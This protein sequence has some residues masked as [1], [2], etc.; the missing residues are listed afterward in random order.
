MYW[1]R[2]WLGLSLS[3]SGRIL[4]FSKSRFTP[5]ESDETHSHSDMVRGLVPSM[6][7][8]K[9]WSILSWWEDWFLPWQIWVLSHFDMTV[10]C[11]PT[12]SDIRAIAIIGMELPGEVP[13]KLSFR[14]KGHF[15]MTMR[16]VLT[17]SDMSTSPFWCDWGM[18]SHLI[19]YKVWFHS[20][21]EW[22][23]L[24]SY[25]EPSMWGWEPF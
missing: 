22:R 19:R 13:G 7:R 11:V 18:C 5:R 14:T 20:L 4:V 10:G 16:C 2:H 15:D 21:E 8:C 9:G 1:R 6:V 3:T 12:W 25:Q 23:H 24:V 17:W